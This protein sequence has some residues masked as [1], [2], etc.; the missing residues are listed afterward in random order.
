MSNMIRIGVRE[1]KQRA[2]EWLRRVEA[3]ET[4]EVASRGRPIALLV[5][6]PKGDQIARLKADGRLTT[7]R[8][9]LLSLGPPLRPKR[10][11]PLPSSLLE[12]LRAAER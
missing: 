2:S 8:E 7:A 6:I 12:E 1:L 9:D 11:A 10:G 3:G 5:P 4:L